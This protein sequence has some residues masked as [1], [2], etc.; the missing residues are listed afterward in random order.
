[1]RK[2]KLTGKFLKED[3]NIIITR[4]DK[5]NTTVVIEKNDYFNEAHTLLSNPKTYEVLVKT[6]HTVSS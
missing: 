6:L 1:M 3:T 5:D 2:E 4:A